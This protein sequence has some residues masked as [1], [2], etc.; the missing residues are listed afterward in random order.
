MGKHVRHPNW[1]DCPEP[2]AVN[3]RGKPLEFI[4]EEHLRERQICAWIDEIAQGDASDDVITDVI[5]FLKTE[6]PLHIADEEE[7][8]FPLL[9]RRCEPEDE[10]DKVIAKLGD[11]HG[12]SDDAAHS[13][14]STLEQMV[15]EKRS[16]IAA[17]KQM[18][19]SFAAHARRHLILENA[20][21]LPFA[22]LRLT[23]RDLET[24]YLRMCQR[25]NL[26]SLADQEDDN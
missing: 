2:T 1:R 23:E 6:L 24:L 22:R 26:S 7:D 13:V 10:I 11:D 5:A 3:F 18:L 25:R 21:I 12:D 14:L 16:L 9:K 8:L 4:H 17:E 15:A 19:T 20:I